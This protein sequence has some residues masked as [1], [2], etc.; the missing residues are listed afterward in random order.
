MKRK[1]VCIISFLLLVSYSLTAAAMFSEQII[2]QNSNG[3]NSIAGGDF[4]GDGYSDILYT[5]YQSNHVQWLENDGSLNF[6]AHLIVDGLNR[7]RTIDVYDID[8]NGTLD[9]VLGTRSKISWFS[10]DGNGSFTEHFISNTWSVTNMVLVR[11]PF[12]DTL[13]DINGDGEVDILVTACS[14]GVLAWFENDGSENFSEHIIKDDFTVISGASAADIDSDGDVDIFAA[15]HGEGIWWFENDGLENFTGHLIF[16]SWDKG[17][18]IQAG[19]I[20]QDGDVDFTATSCG[21]SAAVGW[22]ENDGS[23]NF[24]L[25]L[26]KNNFNGGRSPVICDIDEDGDYDIFATAWQASVTVFFENDGS[27]NFTERIISTD[28]Y[29]LLK[30]YV[31]D[32]DSDGDQDL[33]AGSA[34]YATNHIRWWENIDSFVDADFSIDLSTGHAPLSVNFTEQSYSKPSVDSWAWD[35]NSDGIYDSYDQHPNWIYSSPGI[36]TVTLIASNSLLS[37]TCIKDSIIFV[38]DGESALKFTPNQSSTNCPASPGLNI[39]DSLTIEAWI[40]PTGWGPNTTVGYGTILDKEEFTVLLIKGVYGKNC[41][42]LKMNHQEGGSS[43]TMTPDSSISLHGWL[44]IAVTYGYEDSTVK[45]YI[46]GVEQTLNST[47]PPSGKIADNLN[48]DLSIGFYQ[49][50]NYSFD[51]IIDEVRLWNIVRSSQEVYANMGGY[52]SGNEAGLVGYWKM[53][54]GWGDSLIDNS[55]NTYNFS[56]EDINWVQG[57]PFHPTGID[58]IVLPENPFQLHFNLQCRVLGNSKV[59]IQME[60]P[61]EGYIALSIYDIQGRK[62]EE[63]THGFY[64]CGLYNFCWDLHDY[65]LGLYFVNLQT[66]YES[67]SSKILLIR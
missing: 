62:I 2:V 13:M 25:H 27:E 64:H 9:F 11:D 16:N 1:G 50:F 54:E 41:L 38:F 44:H 49:N 43:L 33:I 39:T 48:S 26:L 65:P 6:T 55:V 32:L 51:G 3:A 14:S 21:T 19:D 53:N 47:N 61:A 37:D 59:N 17:N 29:D 5:C 22:F 52:L 28:A 24:T 57:T 23:E 35:F 45:I 40:Y 8:Q 42:G 66:E 20:D 10:N 58:E 18:R 67:L 34:V 36:Y 7:P 30:L 56:V 46:N 60:I 12:L 4:N 31:I 63:I 15:A